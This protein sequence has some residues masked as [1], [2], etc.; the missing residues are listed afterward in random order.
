[1]GEPDLYYLRVTDG[2]ESIPDNLLAGMLR[3]RHD[4]NPDFAHLY[5]AVKFWY[6]EA[7][8]GRVLREVGFAELVGADGGFVPVVFG[9]HGRNP[10]LW[11]TLEL[12]CSRQRDGLEVTR[13]AFEAAWDRARQRLAAEG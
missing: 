3:C 9:P 6:V 13:E 2:S 12:G 11:T 7:D 8:R 10:G 1:M 5:P 4:G